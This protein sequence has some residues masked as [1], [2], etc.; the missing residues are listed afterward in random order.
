M[1]NRKTLILTAGLGSAGLLVGAYLFQALGYAPC[2]LCYWQRYPHGV[3]AGLAVLV[4]IL[5][6]RFWPILAALGAL[7]AATTAGI[8]VYHVGVEQKW[9]AGPSSC[10][11]GGDLSGLSGAELLSTD[12]LDKVV[13]CDEVSWA[14]LGISMPGWNA[15]FSAL[16]VGLWVLAALRQGAAKP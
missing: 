16:L 4:L 10:S 2:K 7:A 5:A 13:M 14:L 11:G 12:V 3:A 15:I 8:G 6:P 1:A 9:W